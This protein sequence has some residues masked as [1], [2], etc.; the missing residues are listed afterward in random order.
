MTEER[1]GGLALIAGSAGMIV[2][3]SL[4]PTGHDLF[5]PG[6]LER[7]THVTVA[8]HALALVSLP[9]MFLGAMALT[10]RLASPGRL[11]TSGL[12][13]F[14]FALVAV[15]HAAVV[16]GLIAP[17]LIRQFLEAG[18]AASDDGW[19]I[20][21]HYNSAVNQ[22]FA[23]VHVVASSVAVVLWSAAIV[24]GRSL[25]RGVGVYGCVLGPMT[26]LALLSGHL[27]LN[28]HGMGLVVLGQAI[29]YV[30][31]GVLMWRVKSA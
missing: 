30:I 10:R 14:G 4:H 15:M 3:M 31:V 16:S 24:R 27:R 19:K 9:V 11:A 6:Q 22:A 17:G 13:L 5:T 2:T 28:V 7:M 21:L 12:V 26:V 25:A 1:K 18:R 23:Q 8:A 29:W 20:A